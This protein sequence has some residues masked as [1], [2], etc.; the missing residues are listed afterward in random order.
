LRVPIQEGIVHHIASNKLLWE[1]GRCL[2]WLWVR[3]EEHSLRFSNTFQ[4][5]VRI[6]F[7]RCLFCDVLRQNLCPPRGVDPIQGGICQMLIRQWIQHCQFIQWNVLASLNIKF[8]Y[9]C[10]DMMLLNIIVEWH[11]IPE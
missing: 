3:P 4:Y 10:D 11:F 1:G 5:S 7:S 8:V 9:I 6:L 2:D